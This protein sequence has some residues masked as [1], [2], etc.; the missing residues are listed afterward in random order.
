MPAVRTI[1]KLNRARLNRARPGGNWG[2]RTPLSLNHP[3]NCSIEARLFR[4]H[5]AAL[6]TDGTIYLVSRDHHLYAL[7]NERKSASE[8]QYIRLRRAWSKDLAL[9]YEWF[10]REGTQ[11]DISRLKRD[12]PH[13]AWHRQMGG[14]ATLECAYAQRGQ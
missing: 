8:G 6:A 12:Y 14:S 7:H 2:G 3:A 1:V 13:I 9:A 5:Q 4:G 10:E 11:I